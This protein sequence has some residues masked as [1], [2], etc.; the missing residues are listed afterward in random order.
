MPLAATSC[1]ATVDF[2]P[3]S[4]PISVF[5]PSYFAAGF[6]FR[7]TCARPAFVFTAVSI[8]VIISRLHIFLERLLVLSSRSRHCQSR[9]LLPR[10]LLLRLPIALL[11]FMLCAFLRLL[12]SPS[13][14]L[15]VRY[16]TP[17]ITKLPC[18]A[19]APSFATSQSLGS[20]S[21][22]SMSPRSYILRSLA[23]EVVLSNRCVR[24]CDA[25]CFYRTY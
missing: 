20:S 9:F 22:P 4:N 21:R 6:A 12:V 11:R 19:S 5:F 16:S 2:A 10:L 17:F 1:G 15:Q 3:N 24:N 8:S 13:V 7:P 18:F 25:Q 14:C 23:P